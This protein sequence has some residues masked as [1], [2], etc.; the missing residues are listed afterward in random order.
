MT[1]EGSR[2][3]RLGEV[4]SLDIDAVPVH[5]AETYRIAGVYS[6]AR[7]LFERDP[8]Q[9]SET[10]YA[11]FHRLREGQLVLSRLKAW[12][13][14]MA[15]V[16]A[17]FDGAHLSTEFPTFSCHP[18]ALLPP[19]AWLLVQRPS[20]WQTLKGLSSGMG[21]RK[22]RVKAEAFLSVTVDLPSLDAQ[23]RVVDLIDHI[24]RAVKA[25]SAMSTQTAV[26]REAAVHELVQDARDV[27][28]EATLGDIADFQ[29][30][31]A[32]KKD[33]LGSKGL[34]VVRIRELFDES[35]EMGC[36]DED[37]YDERHLLDNGDLIF[38]WSGRLGVK[39]WER[40]PALLNQ[41]LFKVTSSVDELRLG[42]LALALE[43]AIPGLEETMHGST[44]K[45]ITKKTLTRWP[46]WIPPAEIQERATGIIAAIDSCLA[47]GQEFHAQLTNTRE[48]V[49]A[50][51]LS[52]PLQVPDNYDRFLQEVAA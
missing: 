34:P 38:T 6:F 29:N 1:S 27:G 50:S 43:S 4:M 22:T 8:L 10:S 14:A 35:L 7:G 26:L 48:A 47:A 5:D 52:N 44:M 17:E 45:H 51:L 40:G 28:R 9:G 49:L 13:G 39:F 46:V 36:Y 41:H 16:P 20:F 12:E 2:S 31:G 30:G 11:K 23:R 24:D 15:P 21:G 37:D 33:L 18:E 32:F 19:Y 42:Y 25:A 3:V